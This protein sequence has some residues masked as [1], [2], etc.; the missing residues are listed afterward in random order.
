MLQYPMRAVAIK[1]GQLRESAPPISTPQEMGTLRCDACGEQFT[2]TTMSSSQIEPRLMSKLTGSK[3]FWRR[4][5]SA[6]ANIQTES[7]CLNSAT[8][9]TGLFRS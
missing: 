1:K 8:L 9:G 4:N 5:M 6:T 3:R 7:S 2:F